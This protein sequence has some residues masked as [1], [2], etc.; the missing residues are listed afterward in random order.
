MYKNGILSFL[1]FLSIYCL[2]A[3]ERQKINLNN[4]WK[5]IEGYKVN[6]SDAIDIQLPHTYNLDAMSAKADYYRGAAD[7][8]K[9]IEIPEDWKNKHLYLRFGAVNQVATVS[10]NGKT[11]GEHFGGYNAFGFDISDAVNFGDKN[12]I[13]VRVTNA[14]DLGIMPLLGDFNFY[15]GIYRDVDLMV[16]PENHI[17]PSKYAANGVRIV[18]K[19]VSDSDAKFEVTA[20]VIGKATVEVEILDEDKQLIA[21]KKQRVNASKEAQKVNLDFSIKNP[22]LWNGTEDPHQYTAVIKFGEDQILQKFGLRY[23]EVDDAN[24]FHLNG[25]PLILKGVGK[26]QDFSNIG[27]AISKEQMKLDVEIMKEMGV[28]A[29]RLTHYPHDPYLVELLNEAGMI[30][31]TE[32]PFV[33]PGGYRAKGFVNTDRFKENGKQQLHEL[34]DQYFNHPSVLFW[35]LFNEL[36]ED[37]DNP[38]QYIKELNQLAKKEDPSR[39]T[40]AASN[41]NGKLNEITDLIAFNQYFGWY[42]GD[43]A[44]VGT[45]AKNY[46]KNNPQAKLGLSEYGAGAS[47][48]HQQDSLKKPV[49]NSRWHPENWQTHFHEEHL[50]VFKDDDPFWGTFVWV[51]FDFYAAHRTEGERDGVNDKGLV[52]LDRNIKKDAFYLYK[53]NWNDTDKF[54][55]I[56]ER[57]NSVRSVSDQDFKIYSNTDEV[58]LFLNEKSLG[59]QK[60]DG[61]GRFTWKNNQLQKG[62]NYLKAVSKQA[63][64]A[65]EV[66]ITLE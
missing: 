62:R 19:E 14:L 66:I 11:I 44:G 59:V 24:H 52:S 35:G 21:S 17:I 32:I 41:R 29:V 25:N 34:I 36:K 63:D 42:G 47:P 4:D 5:F 20:R 57:R 46:R 60:N 12:V 64:K 16:L 8:F 45:W 51:M 15:G 31:W 30:V 10:I 6:M 43:P 38:V 33:G 65:D 56:A 53:A 22:R 1:L 9:E 13:E 23:F 28:N 54:V 39:Y 7:Y 58:E 40:V 37:G 26:H 48:Y 3:Q 55:Y 27:N 50:K 61:Y 49:A 2:S 18:Q